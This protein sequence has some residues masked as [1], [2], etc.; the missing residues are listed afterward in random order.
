VTKAA[1]AARVRTPEAECPFGMVRPMLVQ[2]MMR[3]NRGKERGI[4][5]TGIEK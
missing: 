5:M 2:T 1:G 3:S 4:S